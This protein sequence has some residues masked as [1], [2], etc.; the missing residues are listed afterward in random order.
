MTVMP[1]GSLER[2]AA[3]VCSHI[4]GSL[5]ELLVEIAD[6]QGREILARPGASRGP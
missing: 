3:G 6:E 1:V 4:Y 2:Q 5:S